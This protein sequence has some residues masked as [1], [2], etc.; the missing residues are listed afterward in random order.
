M[1]SL[2]LLTATAVFLLSAPA[3][4]AAQSD[5]DHTVAGG[6]TFPAGWHVRTEPNRQTGQPVQQD[7]KYPGITQAQ[8]GQ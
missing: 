2:R 1:I 3:A 6:G 8:R 7:L 5:P 4:G